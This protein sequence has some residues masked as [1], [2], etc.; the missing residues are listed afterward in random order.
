MTIQA[1]ARV[2]SDL[3]F[4]Q[5][6]NPGTTG[7]AF[8]TPLQ[9]PVIP[10]QALP[11]FNKGTSN[12]TAVT[13]EN[14]LTATL[15][16][17]R[18]G[19][20]TVQP[21]AT[22]R[23]VN[24]GLYEFRQIWVKSGARLEFT[25]PVDVRVTGG[26]SGDNDSYIGPSASGSARPQDAVFYVNTTDNKSKFP[27]AVAI[28]PKAFILAN[29]YAQNGT[30]LLNSGVTGTG[31]FWGKDV[32]VGKHTTLTLATA[33]GGFGMTSTGGGAAGEE[34]SLIE[35]TAETPASIPTTF[36]LEQN[37]PN[38]FNPSTT[39]RYGIPEPADV[40]LT[41]YNA[42][43]QEVTRLVEGNREAGYHVVHW[44]G[45]NRSGLTVGTGIYFYRLTA[46]SFVETK[47]AILMK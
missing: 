40:T 27:A 17:G 29:V 7:G 10:T 35:A 45:I 2:A 25:L 4:N 6:T 38:P 21:G 20:V 24:Q 43:G 26:L 18:Y 37:Y 23:L 28:S 12:T 19:D 31:S 39:I 16:A 9:T 44:E 14:G 47:K 33:F 22:L 8:F 5:L 36:S 1:G 41:I 11:P 42:L 3:Y 46:G 13:V 32:I 30:I 34:L 15:T